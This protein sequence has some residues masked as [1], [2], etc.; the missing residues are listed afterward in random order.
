MRQCLVVDDSNIIRRVA[1]KILEDL[2]FE[3]LEAENGQQAIELCGSSS[4]DAILL[5]WHMPDMTGI[6]AIQ[7]LR[8][9]SDERKPYIVYAVTENDAS[10]ITRALTA[11]ADDFVL[12]PF[13]RRDLE[14]KF[15]AAASDFN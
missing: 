4:P 13:D 15:S 9:A 11:G 2:R 5:D 1:R 14:A 6:E 8:S 7:Q 12:K 3:V 10:D